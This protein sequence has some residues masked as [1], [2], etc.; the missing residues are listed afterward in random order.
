M[1]GSYG[2]GVGK[3]SWLRGIALDVQDK[4]YVSDDN[5]RISVFTSGGQFV[6]SFGSKGGR[7]GEFN[8]PCGLAVDSNGVV[9]VCDFKNFRLQLF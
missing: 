2:K 5:N 8:N 6:T 1:F 7:P 3:L 9:Y 4:V